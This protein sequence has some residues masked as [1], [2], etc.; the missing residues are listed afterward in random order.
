VRIDRGHFRDVQL[1]GLHAAL[2][3]AWPGP[4]FEGKGAMQA[5]IDERADERAKR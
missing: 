3:Y 2:L 5:I 1:A 4:I